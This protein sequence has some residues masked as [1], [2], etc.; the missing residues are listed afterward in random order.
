MRLIFFLILL[1]LIVAHVIVS[2]LAIMQVRR[3]KGIKQT[4][5][6][7][8]WGYSFTSILLICGCFIAFFQID[9]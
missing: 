2:G 6:W 9:F 5:Q 3:F 1:A 8:I 7:V 4:N